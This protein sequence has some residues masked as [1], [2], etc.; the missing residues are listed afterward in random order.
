MSIDKIIIFI[1]AAFMIIGSLDKIFGNKYGMGKKFDEGFMSMGSLALSMLGA[2]SLAPVLANILKPMI[3][4]IYTFLGADP[5]VFAPTILANDMGGYSLAMELAGTEQIGLFSGLVIGAIMGPTFTFTIP[6]ALS[7][8]K[9]EDHEYLAKGVLAG[10]IAVPIGCFV[11]GLVAYIS[12]I[13]LLHNLFPIII[14]A[15]LIGLGLYKIPDKII[16]SF[17]I[18]GD[19]VMGI[20]TF[21]TACI[22]FETLT[23]IV[24]IPGMNPIWDGIKTVGSISILLAGAFPMVYFIQKVFQ[25]PMIKLG[26]YMGI[27]HTSVA[28]LLASF[29]HSIP[30]FSMLQDMDKKGK[31]ANVAFAVSGAFVFGSH[32]GFTAG[33]SKEMIVPVIIGKLVSGISAIIVSNLLFSKKQRR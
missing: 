28:G 13:V 21:A 19:M 32:L 4:P 17:T 1:M 10:L 23:G 24:I 5:S 30:M 31:I 25:K 11:G 29:A 15:A 6:V 12:P 18:F 16:K 3:V 20:I 22:V 9:R 8:I 27:S 14:V 2:V 33:V 26:A 7:I